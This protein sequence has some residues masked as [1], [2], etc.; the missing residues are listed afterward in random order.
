LT[1]KV[2]DSATGQ[3]EEG[4]AAP[5]L[6][7]EPLRQLP[8]DYVTT[9]IEDQ[10]RVHEL[11][12]EHI[13]ESLIDERATAEQGPQPEPDQRLPKL[14]DEKHT[15]CT[16][17]NIDLIRLRVLAVITQDNARRLS[18]GEKV[19]TAVKHVWFKADD[20]LGD[21]ELRPGNPPPQRDR[22][23]HL[24]FRQ[25]EIDPMRM[26]DSLMERIA[27]DKDLREA[28]EKH[29]AGPCKSL[30]LGADGEEVDLS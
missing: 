13:R 28:Y 29:I 30:I 10:S 11:D 24:R 17:E 4:H 3:W 14:P 22:P 18:A 23:R 8:S 27:K 5:R 15:R 25:L 12:P 16:Q 21:C 20:V 6:L 26:P 1:A 19:D 2:L 9:E 7:P